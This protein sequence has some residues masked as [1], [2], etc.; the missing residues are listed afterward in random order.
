MDE[1]VRFCLYRRLDD[2]KVDIAKKL[3]RRLQGC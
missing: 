3:L 2:Y 1:E